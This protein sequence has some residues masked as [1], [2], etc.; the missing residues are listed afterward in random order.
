MQTR[1]PRPSPDRLALRP[2]A[3]AVAAA[4]ALSACGMFRGGSTPDNE[5]T[6]K[7]LANRK[8]T[9]DK[10]DVVAVNEKKAIEAYRKFLDIAPAAPQRSEA[11][12]RLGDLEM[13]SADSDSLNR[14]EGFAHGGTPVGGAAPDYKAAVARYQEYLKNYPN[15]PNNDRVLYQMARAY[16][17]TGD[18]E[19]AQKTLAR[20]V[21]DYPATRYAAEAQ[22]RRGEL[23]FTNKDYAGAEKAFE[24]VLASPDANPY[25]DRS[26]YMLGWSQYKQGRLEDGLKSFLG[27]LDIKVAGKE[28]ETGLD[29]IAGLTRAER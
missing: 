18:L 28:G 9:V 11:M 14:T 22:F 21:K 5:P 8:V 15:D 10:E 16:E 3:L 7:T 12:R 26:L 19:S 23:L 25:R 1:Q 17:Q 4:C 13:D 20:L 29:A 27:V 24:T 6:L 2:A